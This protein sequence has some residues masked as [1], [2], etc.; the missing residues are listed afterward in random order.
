MKGQGV[1]QNRSARFIVQFRSQPTLLKAR[2]SNPTAPISLQK[3]CH[4]LREKEGEESTMKHEIWEERR[5]FNH[6]RLTRMHC[7][8]QIQPDFTER[9]QHEICKFEYGQNLMPSGHKSDEDRHRGDRQKRKQGSNKYTRC[10]AEPNRSSVVLITADFLQ[11]KQ[12]KIHCFNKM[13]KLMPSG[14]KPEG[15]TQMG[16]REQREPERIE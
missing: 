6:Q 1:F 2:N 10:F 3:R 15:D 8:I 7:S 16:D 9:M 5:D 12:R 11:S 13:N 14:Q 4:W